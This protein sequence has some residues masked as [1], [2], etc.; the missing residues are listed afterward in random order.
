[1][2]RQTVLAA[3]RVARA[4]RAAAAA[5]AAAQAARRA[6]RRPTTP[7]AS[8]TSCRPARTGS[9]TRRS[10]PHSRPPA[11]YPPHWT[12]QQ[13]LYDGLID[14]APDA[15]ATRRSPNYYKDATFGVKAGDV[16]STIDPAPG[17]D[18]RARQRL[19]RP[20]RLRRH[21]RRRDVRRRLRRT[22]QDRLFLMDVLRH[23]GRRELSS[24]VGGSAGN[25]AM[26][27]ASGRSRPTP[28]PTCSR[29]FD[30]AP[31]SSTAPQGEQARQNDVD[32]PTSPASTP[33]STTRCSN[34]TKLPGRVRG[35]GQAA[36]STG[37]RPT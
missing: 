11:R 21:A 20:A 18:D 37:S 9:T 17:R 1:M 36:D 4:L 8:A 28:K 32:R 15:D 30:H 13:P 10:S 27:R 3:E 26:D 5:P 35:A 12:D 29:Q 14:G 16:E 23:T 31:T 33:T 7:A 25:R 6:L 2:S 24:F 19:R 22:P 34:P